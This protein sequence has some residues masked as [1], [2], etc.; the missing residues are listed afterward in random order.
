M[1][2]VASLQALIDA[3]RLTFDVGNAE[4]LKRE[5]LGI[6][7]ANPVNANVQRL[8]VAM[9]G[10]TPNRALRVSSLI[11][12]EGHHSTGL[13]VDIGNEE[14]AAELL[15]RIAIQT[16]VT[17]LGIDEIIFDA[18]LAGDANRNRY[19]FDRGSPHAY[20]NATLQHH[21]DH[22]HFSVKPA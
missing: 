20:D 17:R 1:S 14:L 6:P 7:P 12:N 4:L 21:R 5:L 2:Y 8:V 9:C 15:P 16:E 11:R 13:A 3:G 10:A 19:N 18:S 22:I